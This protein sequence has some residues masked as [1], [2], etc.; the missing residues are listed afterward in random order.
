MGGTSLALLHPQVRVGRDDCHD[1]T[2]DLWQLGV[3]TPWCQLCLVETGQKMVMPMIMAKMGIRQINPP[4]VAVAK[5]A[6]LVK[7]NLRP[8]GEM[9]LSRFTDL[10]HD[11]I[12]ALIASV[13]VFAVVSLFVYVR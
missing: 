12:F 5:N 9:T 8:Y 13:F 7:H 3:P 4:H 1:G 2:S 6:L 10:V 11:S